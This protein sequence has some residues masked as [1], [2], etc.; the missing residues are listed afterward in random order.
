MRKSVD[1]KQNCCFDPESSNPIIIPIYY[2]CLVTHTYTFI[3]FIL[4]IFYSMHI[5]ASAAASG[6]TQNTIFIEIFIYPFTAS[7]FD[8]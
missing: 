1:P 8:Y 2:I 5:L 4:F 6:Q 3:Y 7:C